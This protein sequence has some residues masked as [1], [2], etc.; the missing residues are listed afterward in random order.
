MEGIASNP[1]KCTPNDNPITNE[2]SISH[3]SDLSFSNSLSHFKPNQNKTERI[4]VAMA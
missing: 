2:M 3:L 1:M 4:R